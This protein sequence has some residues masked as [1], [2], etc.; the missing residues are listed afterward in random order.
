MSSRSHQNLPPAEAPPGTPLHRGGKA[1]AVSS[2]L[3]ASVACMAAAAQAG[4]LGAATALVAPDLT[5]AERRDSAEHL[6][7]RAELAPGAARA[8][9]NIVGSDRAAVVLAAEAAFRIADEAPD[10]TRGAWLAE[11]VARARYA[12]AAVPASGEAHLWLA[13]SLASEAHERGLLA[14]IGA[15]GEVRAAL[16][17]AEARAPGN[18]MILSALCSLYHRAPS[19][20]LSFGDEDLSRGYCLRA[21]ALDPRSWEAHL[22]LAEQAGPARGSSHLAAILD[23]PLDPRL[24]RTHARYRD[25][26]RRLREQGDS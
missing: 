4:P 3:A 7:A 5:L 18:A 26:A 16:H 9:L 19:W 10:P 14:L 2:L 22:V 17:A 24:P 1:T 8:A 23:G 20:P 25:Q 11:A 6:L 12:V 15:S 13:I 21:L